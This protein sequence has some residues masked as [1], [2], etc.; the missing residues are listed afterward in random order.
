MRRYDVL[1]R[2]FYVRFSK[3]TCGIVQLKV[4]GERHFIS[5]DLDVVRKSILLESMIQLLLVHLKG[6]LYGKQCVGG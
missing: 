5:F 4:S 3:L 6:P 1:Q 2:V